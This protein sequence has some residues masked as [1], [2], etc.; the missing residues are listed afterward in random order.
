MA[1]LGLATAVQC[2]RVISS[3]CACAYACLLL[4]PLH[5]GGLP[6]ASLAVEALQQ[7]PG[8]HRKNRKDPLP[9]TP[10]LQAHCIA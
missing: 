6:T 9:K 3:R 2:V 8:L 5:L 1:W 4:T 7:S 10:A